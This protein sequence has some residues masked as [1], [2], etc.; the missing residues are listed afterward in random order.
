MK[1]VLQPGVSYQGFG[2]SSLS[3]TLKPESIRPLLSEGE[4]E[5]FW[6]GGEREVHTEGGISK[7]ANWIAQASI[8]S[9]GWLIFIEE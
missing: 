4:R 7:A 5:E 8:C 9:T 3:H 2:L 6:R 1:L